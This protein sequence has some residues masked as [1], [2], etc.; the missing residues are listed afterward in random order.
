MLFV[1]DHHTQVVIPYILLKQSVCPDNDLRLA[2][3]NVGQRIGPFLF[4][5][6]AGDQRHGNAVGRQKRVK[7]FGMLAG[8]DFGRRHV[9]ALIT[10]KGHPVGARHRNDGFAAANVALDQPVHHLAAQKIRL[11]FRQYLFLPR[12]QGKGQTILKSRDRRQMVK[13]DV[14]HLS[15]DAVFHNADVDLQR[16]LKFHP[17]FAPFDV[18]G[19]FGQM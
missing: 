17:P 1:C 16:F 7:I 10:A 8:Q 2:A 3:F 9:G 6:A 11:N 4:F 18:R 13:M 5:H 12:R 14:R 19:R 15:S